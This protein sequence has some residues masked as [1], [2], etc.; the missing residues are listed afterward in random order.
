[1][2][3][4]THVLLLLTLSH[5]RSSFFFFNDTATTEIYT[6]SL[7]DALPILEFNN[8]NT[9]HGTFLKGLVFGVSDDGRL[10]SDLNQLGAKATGRI[11]SRKFEKE[12]ELTKVMKRTGEVRITKKMVKVGANLQNIPARKDKDP[13]GIRGAFRAPRLGEITASGDVAEEEHT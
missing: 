5:L 3:I 4:P 10:R 7:H 1:M 6:L 2:L 8:A 11:S 12:V 9:L 13:D